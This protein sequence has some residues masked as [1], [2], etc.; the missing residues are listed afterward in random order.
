ESEAESWGDND[1]EDD[2]DIDK[3]DNE[4]TDDDDN[5]GNNDD[6]D[7]DDGD[8]SDDKGNDDADDDDEQKDEDGEKVAINVSNS[9][10]DDDDE[11]DDEEE[12]DYELLYRDVNVN[13]HGDVDMTRAEESRDQPKDQELVLQYEDAHVTLTTSQKTEGQT[14]SSSVSSSF[15]SKF[16]DLEN[17]NP[18]DYTMTTLMDTSIPPHETT[19]STPTTQ[20]P[21]TSAPDLPDFASI[22]KFNERVFNLEQEVS[23]LKQYDKSAK[24][25]KTVKSHVPVLIDEHLSTRDGYAVQTAFHSYKVDFEKEAQ[26]EQDRFIDI[27]DKTVK[28]LVKDEVKGQINKILPKKIVD[29]ATPMIERNVD[30]SYE[31]V[32]LAKSASQPKSN[33]EAAASLTEFELKNILHDKMDESESY[34]AAQEH[35]YLYDCVAKYYKLDKDLFDTYG[36]AYSLK[37]DRDDK[38]KDEDPSAGSDRGMKRQKSGKEEEPSQE[39]KSKSSKSTGSSKGP[40]QSP[41][42]SFGKSAHAKESRQDSGEPHD[43]E[44]VTGNTD[45]QP[46]DEVI[47][48]DAWWKKPEKPPTPDRD[49]N[50]RQSI[51]FRPAQPW[52][53]KMA[54]DKE[55]PQSF[56]EL[57]NTP[58]DFTAFVMN[59]LK[60]ENLTQETLVEPAL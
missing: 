11:K 51:D 32:V 46:A 4:S 19:T 13:L 10:D 23:H 37:R 6:D 52:I 60:I 47:S 31:R 24:I 40:N 41:R 2:V 22:F 14:Q 38:D 18:S 3:S 28:E 12:D 54:K 43:Q 39:P 9:D 42:K 1:D 26:A 20:E 25:S 8:D 16:L 55:S 34:R 5:D 44:F 45:E 58:I 33:Y 27:I 56:D 36:K 48:K 21:Q 35:R 15:T 57:M 30:D 53:T 7:D 50:K 29:F 49:W 17:V 59:R